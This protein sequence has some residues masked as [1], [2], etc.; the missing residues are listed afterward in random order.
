MKIEVITCF[1]REHYLAPLFMQHYETWVDKITI[2]TEKL[3]GTK[4]DGSS[5]CVLNDHTKMGWI[6]DAVSK[7]NADWIVVVD[8]DEFVF[9]AP[10]G[11]DPRDFLESVPAN[12]RFVVAEMC[13]VWTHA[14]DADVDL[15][16]PPVPQRIHGEAPHPDYKKPCIFRRGTGTVGI[17]MHNLHDT[18]PE[19]EHPVRW[20][21]A[22]W[23]SATRLLRNERRM[24]DRIS[25]ISKEQYDWQIAYIPLPDEAKIEAEAK[26]HENDPV[27]IALAAP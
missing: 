21:G 19:W 2:I 16:K 12:R 25:R 23:Q 5:G 26:A 22:H 17:G 10:Y 20:S 24:V 27:V 6:R 13:R 4:P 14:S 9:P 18:K 15:M 3:H 8:A 11:T 7:S 1:Y